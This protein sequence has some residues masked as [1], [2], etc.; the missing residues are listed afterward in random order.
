M[1]KRLYRDARKLILL[2]DASV[3]SRTFIRPT[4]FQTVLL[5]ISRA[6][7]FRWFKRKK[8]SF[9][10]VRF[11]RVTTKMSKI[12]RS[13]FRIILLLFY[14]FVPTISGKTVEASDGRNKLHRL[15]DKTTRE[16]STRILN[17]TVRDHGWND[18]LFHCHGERE[19]KITLRP[20]RSTITFTI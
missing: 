2:V 9:D 18:T 6:F 15:N 12:E 17:S 11:S 14:F 10:S 13:I 16:I 4:S 1:T 5:H 7:A 3:A 19:K 8:N 20:N